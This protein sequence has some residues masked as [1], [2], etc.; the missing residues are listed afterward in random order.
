MIAFGS[1]PKAQS[2]PAETP[3]WCPMHPEVRGSSS[4]DTCRRCGMALVPVTSAAYGSYDLDVEMRPRVVRAWQSVKARFLVRQRN[5]GKVVR[6]YSVVHERPF[7]LFVVSHD[8]TY[9]AHVHPEQHL[10]GS[11][12]VTLQL[13]KPGVYRLLTDFVPLDAAPLERQSACV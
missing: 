9:F 2:Q 11:L 3:F 6:E 12:E 13:P 7:H 1:V 4:S 8:L 5:S 10:D